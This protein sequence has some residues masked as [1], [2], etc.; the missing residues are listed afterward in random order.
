MHVG[1]IIIGW[2][3]VGGVMVITG[4]ATRTGI[5]CKYLKELGTSWNDVTEFH[6]KSG[7]SNVHFINLF[8][9]QSKE[10]AT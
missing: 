4:M 3:K 8:F 2:K 10:N 5:K 1:L 6:E 7:D 9:F